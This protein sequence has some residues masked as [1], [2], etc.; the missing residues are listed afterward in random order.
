MRE[1]EE[2]EEGREREE[3][4]RVSFTLSKRIMQRI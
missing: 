1:E 4:K 3:K 2:E